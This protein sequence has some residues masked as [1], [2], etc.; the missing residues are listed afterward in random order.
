MTFIQFNKFRFINLHH[1]QS[2]S[3]DLQTKT[4]SVSLNSTT[5]T[6]QF[7]KNSSGYKTYHEITGAIEKLQGCRMDNVLT[8]KEK[9]DI[10]ITE[11]LSPE[12]EG[13]I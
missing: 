11:L 10:I 8:H 9:S 5:Y 3:Y 2:I 12:L 1:V 13:D 4:L 6:K 7:N